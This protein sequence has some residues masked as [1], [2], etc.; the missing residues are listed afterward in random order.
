[1]R[2]PMENLMH[3]LTSNE[4]S[5][6]LSQNGN[7]Y[8]E[9]KHGILP[10]L[11]FLEEGKLKDSYVADK[12]IGKA[13]AMMMVLGGVKEVETLVISEHAYQFFITHQI[14][15]QYSEKVPYIINR[16]KDGMCPME[17]TVLHID[18]LQEARDAL[19]VKLA[20]LRIK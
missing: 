17:E 2:K 10:I 7:I 15:I 8:T 13:A 4:Y 16:K 14:P 1:M 20:S 18:D 5:C 3:I 9:V 11:Q 12:V 19:Q 6:V